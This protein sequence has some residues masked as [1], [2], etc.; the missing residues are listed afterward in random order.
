VLC[1]TT[2]IRVK[3]RHQKNIDLAYIFQHAQ[4]LP[5]IIKLLRNQMLLLKKINLRAKVL[6]ACIFIFS[7]KG[8]EFWLLIT[9][10]RKLPPQKTT[11]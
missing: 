1:P 11:W 6:T 7:A 2:K 3:Y 8:S 10:I 5:Q 9:C 4:L